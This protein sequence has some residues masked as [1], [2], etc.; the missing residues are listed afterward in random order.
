MYL[1]A[2][3]TLKQREDIARMSRGS[4]F[5]LPQKRKEGPLVDYSALT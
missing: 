3:R 2:Q 4:G 5:Y 1:A